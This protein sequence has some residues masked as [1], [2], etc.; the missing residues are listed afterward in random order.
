MTTHLPSRNIGLDLVRITESTALAAS[1]WIGSGDYHGV[2]IA[3]CQ[4][5]SNA[6]KELHITGQ[7]IIGEETRI[8]GQALLCGGTQVGDKHKTGVDLAVDPI[9]GT[10]LLIK[11]RP[12]A[13]SL[14]G[15]VPQGSLWSPGPAQYV[16]KLIVDRE[17]ADVLVPECMDAPAAWTL[18]L[19]AR[20]KNKALLAAL[21]DTGF[22]ILMGTGGA[23]QGVLAAIAVKALGSK[24]LMRLAPNDMEE[25][26]MI[27]AV[28]LDT[29]KIYTCDELVK[30][31]EIAFA[32][33]G[34]TASPLLP[35][36]TIRG[37]YAH[38]H[39][40]LIRSETGTRRHIH[41]EY[42]LSD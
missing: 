4:A 23:T 14:M 34:I 9:D 35:G 36:I 30:S 2:H 12:G 25:R 39:S 27:E 38:M 15:T 31:N 3:A 24:M 11:G 19:I 21:V 40:L 28:G 37:N 17:A 6:I 20:A 29:K 26:E 33:T 13:I 1:R 41:T 5:M 10:N 32:A 16:D 8:E 42:L 7:I 18:S 22:D